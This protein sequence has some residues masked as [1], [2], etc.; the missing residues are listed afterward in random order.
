MKTFIHKYDNLSLIS[1]FISKLSK[2]NPPMKKDPLLPSANKVIS[3][4]VFI[5]LILTIL[6][7]FPA[8]IPSAKFNHPMEG[9]NGLLFNTVLGNVKNSPTVQISD[10]YSD[11]SPRRKYGNLWGQADRNGHK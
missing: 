9:I 7:L 8:C 6:H 3:N 10:K 5:I 1:Y 4:T 2:R 11:L